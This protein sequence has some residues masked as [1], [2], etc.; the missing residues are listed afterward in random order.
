MITA[1]SEGIKISVETKFRNDLSQNEKGFYFF[2]YDIVIENQNSFEV[3]L[4]S[5]YW[6][7]FDSLD[8]FRVVEGP[9]VVGEQPIISPENK[10]SYLS[11][12]DLKSEIGYM[13]G[14]YIFKNKLTEQYFKVQIPRFELVYPNRLN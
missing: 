11:G 3:Q 4:I 14:Y 13:E 2:S 8:D 12:C 1:V 5:R 7:I 9:G 6:N 10:F